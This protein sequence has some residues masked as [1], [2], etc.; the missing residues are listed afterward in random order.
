MVEGPCG[1]AAAPRGW[2][3]VPWAIRA[4]GAQEQL[5][6]AF[7]KAEEVGAG[8]VPVFPRLL[9][10]R[11]LQLAPWPLWTHARLSGPQHS[12]PCVARPL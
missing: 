6:T 3:E 2:L 5:L 1:A 12:H 10:P 11:A 7:Q 9:W 8:R 4:R